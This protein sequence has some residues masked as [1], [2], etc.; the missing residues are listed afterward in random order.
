MTSVASV[1]GH[2]KVPPRLPKCARWDVFLTILKYSST[3]A[4]DFSCNLL[5][6]V[7]DVATMEWYQFLK[8]TNDFAV[9][10]IAIVL[11]VT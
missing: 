8:V 10:E 3:S 9:G 11:T 2:G 1:Q 7:S 6:I 4:N 5:Y